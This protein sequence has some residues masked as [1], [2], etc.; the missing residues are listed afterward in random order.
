MASSI[1]LLSAM[2]VVASGVYCGALWVA[3]GLQPLPYLASRMG[4]HLRDS[5]ELAKPVR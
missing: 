5:F 2:L 1:L 3:S 4:G